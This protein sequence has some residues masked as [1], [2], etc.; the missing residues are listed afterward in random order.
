L[1][2][3]N[4]MD[5]WTFDE[6]AYVLMAYNVREMKSN[7]FD[8]LVMPIPDNKSTQMIRMTTYMDLGGNLYEIRDTAQDLTNLVINEKFCDSLSGK[9]SV[10]VVA[11]PLEK[12]I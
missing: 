7:V 5:R 4:T 1:L 9:S 3:L 8:F 12:A 6:T 2:P 11:S 10:T